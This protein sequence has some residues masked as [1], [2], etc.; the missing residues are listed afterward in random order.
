[1]QNKEYEIT[2]EIKSEII[3]YCELILTSEKILSKE[4]KQYFKNKIPILKSFIYNY[5]VFTFKNI[6]QFE[7]TPEE[8]DE[9]CD[10]LINSDIALEKLLN[11]EII[12][13]GIKDN[14]QFTYE[15]NI[16]ENKIEQN[17][18]NE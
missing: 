11:R 4:F 1:M 8:L 18:I 9:C 16:I 15:E 3:L 13:T 2:E 14:G 17:S 12:L 6:G 5:C 7:L 10:C